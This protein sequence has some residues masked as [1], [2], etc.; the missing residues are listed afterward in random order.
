[1]G[2]WGFSNTCGTDAVSTAFRRLERM[3]CSRVCPGSSNEN[4][5]VGVLARISIQRHIILRSEITEID[6]R[7]RMRFVLPL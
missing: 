3:I 5:E 7:G 4:E 1:M 6:V 2:R